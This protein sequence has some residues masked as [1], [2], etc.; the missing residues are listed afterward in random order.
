MTP[1]DFGPSLKEERERRGISLEE[2]AIATKVS[3]ELWE[4]LERNDLSR[5][6]S[7]VF[8]RAFV[9]D[10]ARTI[11]LDGDAV[12]NEFCRHFRIADRRAARLVQ[13]QAELIG[14][15]LVAD[16]RELL[17]AGRDRRQRQ[18]AAPSS[19]VV[20]YGPRV[21][22]AV[23]DI[24]CVAAFALCGVTAFRTSV[25]SCVGVAAIV[26]FASSTIGLGVSPGVRILEAIRTRVPSLFT[27]RRTVSV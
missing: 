18:P 12:V 24:A 3:V 4:G 27:N 15:R 26:Y 1:D 10:Y 17:P 6:P 11:G 5:W 21:A 19:V 8:A 7:G 2:L 16:D 9:R 25:L 22:A 13:G 20:I 14:H 23:I